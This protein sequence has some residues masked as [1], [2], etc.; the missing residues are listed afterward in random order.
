MTAL[1]GRAAAAGAADAR[2]GALESAAKAAGARTPERLADVD[3]ELAERIAALEGAHA[4][5]DA[6]RKADAEAT[7]DIKTA[8]AALRRDLAAGAQS[9]DVA[10]TRAVS[11]GL[12][13]RLAAL[14][15]RP[16]A[17][18]RWPRLPPTRAP[19]RTPPTRRSA[20]PARRAT[21]RASPASPRIASRSPRSRRGSTSIE[22]AT[23]AP[24]SDMRVA[25]GAGAGRRRGGRAR[26]RGDGACKRRL[27]AGEP[28]AAELAALERLGVAAAS[29]APL[30]RSRELRRAVAG[31]ARA[32]FRGLGAV[33]AR[34]EPARRRRARRP[35]PQNPRRDGGAGENPQGRRKSSRRR[36]G[37]RG[38]HPAPLRRRGDLARAA[39]GPRRAAAGGA[40]GGARL[41]ARRR[42]AARRPTTPPRRSSATR[43]PTSALGDRRMLRAVGFPRSPGPRGLG[44]VVARRQS[45]RGRRDLARRRI[46]CLADGGARHR[47]RRWRSAL[48]L[49]LALLRFVLRAPALMALRQP[50]APAREGL[51]GA[52]ARHDRRRRRRPRARRSARRARPSGYFGDESLT[53]LLRAQAA[54]LSGD[55]A[56][57]VGAFNDMLA[58]RRHAHARPARPAC[59]GAP[60]RRAPTRRSNTPVAPMPAPAPP[61]AAQA[62]LD[63]YAARGDWAD[64]LATVEANAQG[65]ADRPPDRQPLARRVEDGARRRARRARRQVRRWRWPARRSI[66][67]RAW[68]PRRRSA[69]G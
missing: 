58:Q 22:T 65:R 1:E 18:T 69:A 17:A 67:P 3:A 10:Q 25:A 68:F 43:S 16:F 7:Q 30:R 21:T 11:A 9:A 54:Q 60:R 51:C 2:L 15:A 23:A 41:G 57:A 64:A 48:T 63:D 40:R 27:A 44:A 53:K 66:S 61:W 38:A 14:E 31:G 4:T 37:A 49:A 52:V 32:R 13:R 26:R 45:R 50:R 56:G 6:D 19:P 47:A 35:R 34:A 46:Q 39:R 33:I 42:G 20:P 28:L 24:K 5:A 8:I 59:R 36:R 62:V 55:R 29:L 12:E